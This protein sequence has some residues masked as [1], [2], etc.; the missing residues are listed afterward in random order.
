MNSNINPY[1]IYT[2]FNGNSSYTIA[3]STSLDSS[4]VINEGKMTVSVPIEVNGI[5]VEQVLRDLMAATGVV[6]RNRRLE[7]KY[8]GL[9]KEGDAYQ[10]ILRSV[11]NDINVR[12]KQA[13][14][15]YKLA[16]EK[17]KTLEIIKDSK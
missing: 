14:E 11:Q 6:A 5:D 4:L 15:R 12:V 8:K 2:G 17:Y 9:K 3:N 10:E 16:E 13:A 7:E 1:G